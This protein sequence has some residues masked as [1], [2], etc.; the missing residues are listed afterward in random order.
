MLDTWTWSLGFVVSVKSFTDVTELIDFSVFFLL[1]LFVNTG[2]LSFSR[3][4]RR[5]HFLYCFLKYFY[6]VNRNRK[7]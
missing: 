5:V 6:V 1:F 3:A 4:W 7:K 2:D